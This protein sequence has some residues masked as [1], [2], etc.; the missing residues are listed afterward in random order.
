MTRAPATDAATLHVVDNRAGL[1]RAL[2][3]MKRTRPPLFTI[4]FWHNPRR[5]VADLPPIIVPAGTVLLVRT[6]AGLPMLRVTAGRVVFSARSVFGN[7]VTVHGGQ[8]HVCTDGNG[9]KVT[10]TIEPA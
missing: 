5:S 9:R 2:A 4:E 7:A 10:V 3:A 8:V 6:R 1:V